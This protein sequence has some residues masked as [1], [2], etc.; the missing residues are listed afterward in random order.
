ML[1]VKEI[2]YEKYKQNPKEWNYLFQQN[3][4]DVFREKEVNDNAN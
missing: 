1:R 4:K 2:F 3:K